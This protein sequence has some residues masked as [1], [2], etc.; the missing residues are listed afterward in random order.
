LCIREGSDEELAIGQWRNV[1]LVA[2]AYEN[3]HPGCL[4]LAGRQ[5]EMGA[6][7]KAFAAR[8]SVEAE[9]SAEGRVRSIR[10]DDQRSALGLAVNDETYDATIFDERRADGRACMDLDARS[11]CGGFK[12]C[13]IQMPAPLAIARCGPIANAREMA[14]GDKAA[15]MVTHAVKR[16][17]ADGLGQAEPLKDGDAAG[18]ESFAAGLFLGEF[19]ALK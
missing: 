8:G 1:K 16:R 5:T 12:K 7:A 18:H 4:V 13:L 3:I 6:H 9:G 17:A 10:G 2:S 11:G 15:K 19:A 14:F